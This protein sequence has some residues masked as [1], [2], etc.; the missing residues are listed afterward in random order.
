MRIVTWA[1]YATVVY[2]FR[3]DQLRPAEV[4][5]D[6]WVMLTSAAE[7]VLWVMAEDAVA[8]AERAYWNREAA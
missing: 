4:S 1:A 7:Q 2:E 3:Q 8:R 5:L 6:D